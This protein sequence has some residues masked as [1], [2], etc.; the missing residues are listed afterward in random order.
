MSNF[1][2]FLD[3]I[4]HTVNCGVTRWRTHGS[5]ELL[6]QCFTVSDEAFGLLMA[7]NC[8][9]VWDK[10]LQEKNKS[11]WRKEIGEPKCSSSNG[12]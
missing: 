4:L 7:E 8:M 6:S 3:N 2:F 1:E 9:E 12:G 11:K 5:E 10:Q